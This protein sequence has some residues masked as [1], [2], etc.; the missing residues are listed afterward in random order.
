MPSWA[1]ASMVGD[2]PHRG[3]D[4]ACP[5]GAAAGERLDLGA[6]RGDERELGADE[7]PVHG[8]QD[9][10]ADRFESAHR[11]CSPAVGAVSVT[12]SMRRRCTKVTVRVQPSTVTVSPVSA[13]RPSR[14][15]TSP[16]S[17]S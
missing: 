5:A 17:V 2:R 7:E 12:A 9:H 1:P 15:S 3:E 14:A 13:R 11:C 8:E 10:D 4:R 6:A 16:A